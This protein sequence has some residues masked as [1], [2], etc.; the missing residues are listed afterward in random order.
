VA[1]L[2]TAGLQHGEFNL[3]FNPK[4]KGKTPQIQPPNISEPDI[5]SSNMNICAAPASSLPP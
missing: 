2:I 5:R 4:E 3:T 1:Q